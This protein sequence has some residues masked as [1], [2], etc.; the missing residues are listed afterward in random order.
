MRSDSLKNSY[1]SALSWAAAKTDSIKS[2]IISYMS[3]LKA[4]G[5]SKE[6]ELKYFSSEY[7]P[8]F[9]AILPI[10]AGVLAHLLG[11]HG[12]HRLNDFGERD[13]YPPPLVYLIDVNLSTIIGLS[14]AV[15]RKKYP[16]YKGANY[17]I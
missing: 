1:L 9:E 17:A 10:Y 7:E 16:N 6:S 15:V 14:E 13:Y 5:L 8:P 3:P 4:T 12:L 2:K 11:Q